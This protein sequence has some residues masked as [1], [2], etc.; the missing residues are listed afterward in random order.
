M[1]IILMGVSGSG[2]STVGRRLAS[3]SG[4]S[5]YEGDDFHSEENIARMGRGV[6]LTDEDRAPWLRAI[7]KR[8]QAAL[9]R[10]ENAV[11]ACSALKRAYRRMLRVSDEVVFVYLKADAALIRERLKERTGHFMSPELLT[12]QFETLEE[13]EDAVAIDASL[14]AEEIVR[15]IKNKLSV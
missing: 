10:G 2:K 5:F 9:D 11:I 1:I 15:I 12:S 14:P 7:R 6:A 13:P 3:E 8:I 4:W